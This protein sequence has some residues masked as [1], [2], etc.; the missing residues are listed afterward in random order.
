MNSI[1]EY[2]ARVSDTA[3][4]SYNRREFDEGNPLPAK[5][6]VTEDHIS[7]AEAALG[8]ALPPSYRKLMK[9]VHPVDAPVCW[10]WDNE[11]DTLGEEIVSVN[12]SDY[13]NYPEFL[14]VLGGDDSGNAFGFD[15][16][17]PD[18][19]GEYPIVYF[20]HEIHNEDSTDFERLARDLGEFLLGSLPQDHPAS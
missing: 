17:S 9:T 13:A 12:R 7:A 11:T 4:Q 10:I 15:T 14:I 18:E 6:D 8:V 1:D 3:V 20:D 19:R 2:I 16:R 5:P